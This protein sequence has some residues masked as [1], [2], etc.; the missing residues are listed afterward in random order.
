MS[1]AKR[2]RWVE[3]REFGGMARISQGMS[4]LWFGLAVVAG[5]SLNAHQHQKTTH[6]T[7]RTKVD[8]T[9]DKNYI[10]DGAM[11][12]VTFYSQYAPN[13]DKKIPRKGLFV[14]K[15]DAL[16]TV[17]I[18]HG[19]MCDKHDVGF[20]RSLFPDY[21]VMTFDFRAHGEHTKGQCCTLGR[22][23]AYD[24]TAAAQFLKNHPA[25]KGKPLMVYGFS[26][27]AVAA[28]EAQSQKP[29]FDAMMLD[30]PFDSTANIIRKG[31]ENLKFSFFGYEFEVPGR[32][33]LQKY[34]FHPYVQS[35]VKMVLKTV[36]KMDSRDVNTFVHP[37]SSAESVKKI[38][39]PCFFIHCK[40]DE[41]VTVDAIKSIYDGAASDY[42]MLWL[43]NG[44]HHF[45]SFFYNPEKYAA[46]VN[47]FIK[48]VV[49]GDTDDMQ[50]HKIIEDLEEAQ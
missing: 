27:G 28:I 35:L 42:K 11:E 44:R 25:V 33:L 26:M 14:K 1:R 30:C 24:V 23:E 38:N 49:S 17:L 46:L 32:A 21:N 34:A 47:K 48:K 50:Q 29:L 9:R 3:L 6:G 12:Q 31:L 8:H 36:S 19:F 7:K 37:I 45:D 22:D 20:L 40:N 39:I 18:C 5:H 2:I 43:T 15:N 41:K 4:A 16:G 10:E 13:S